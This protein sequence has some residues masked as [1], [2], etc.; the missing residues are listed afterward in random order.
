M[1]L[2]T[3]LPSPERPR[4]RL[5]AHGANV[6]TAPELLAIILRTGIKGCNAVELGQRLITQFGGLRGLLAADAQ[7]LMTV[8]GLGLAKTCE[9]L[10]INELN[11]RALEEDLKSGQALDQ[12]QRVKHYCTA[13]LGHLRIEH[14]I[15][16]YLDSQYRLILAEEISRGTLT[17]ASVYPR[18]II[19]AGLRHHAAALILA[20]NHPSGVA[21]PS[22]ADLA[23]T[24]HLKHAL[25]LVDIRLLDHLIITAGQAVSMAER[26]QI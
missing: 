1:T 2:H 26:G 25:A 3:N 7:T 13:A 10:A 19:K 24:R 23:L 21:E 11:R 22:E 4:E 16:L 17:Q 15:A 5:I 8:D 12:P 20:H 18:E 6:L 14:C 9:L